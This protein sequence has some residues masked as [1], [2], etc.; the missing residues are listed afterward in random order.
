MNSGILRRVRTF[1]GGEQR[2]GDGDGE[3][4]GKLF[5]CRECGTIFIRE[6]ASP[7]P[8]C[9]TSMEHIPNERDLGIG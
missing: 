3:G 1:L 2:N 9:G 5:E 7:C 4:R 8:E 6:T